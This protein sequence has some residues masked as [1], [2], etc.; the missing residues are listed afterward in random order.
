MA[1]HL[2]LHDLKELFYQC[3]FKRLLKTID[4]FH[5]EQMSEVMK[6]DLSM[7]KANAHYELHEVDKT[8]AILR[9]L[10]E[11]IEESSDDQYLY[12]K[13]RLCY[14][15]DRLSEAY[16]Y[17]LDL[18]ENT[19]DK[20]FQ[21]RSLLGLANVLYSQNNKEHLEPI[22]FDLIRFEPLNS[23]DE[24]VSLQILL[25]NYYGQILEE[26]EKAQKYFK[27]A[28]EKATSNSWNY[29]VMRC[30]YGI[31]SN[32][33]INGQQSEMNCVLDLLH[34]YTNGTESKYFRH[35]YNQKFKEQR[36]VSDISLEFDSSNR[37]VLIDNRWL[38]FHD[39]P[40]LYQFLETLHLANS[41]VTKPQIAEALWPH[42]NYKPRIHDPR[43]FNIAKRIRQLIESYENQPVVLLSG[44]LGFKLASQ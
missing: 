43:I 22:I 42:E 23:D 11:E 25:G 44:R 3:H 37:R 39:K 34:A 40:L 24:I 5:T 33:K 18:H 20:S 1:D 16:N 14:F 8:K 35:L 36:F 6:V 38:A 2:Q 29:F 31:A 12:A 41:F 7:L 9:F 32:F 27:L 19:D 26:K 15:E 17:F 4:H 13:A 30:L 10:V 28:L 21:F